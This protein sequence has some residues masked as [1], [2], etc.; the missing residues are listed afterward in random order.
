MR[1]PIAKNSRQ[2]IFQEVLEQALITELNQMLVKSERFEIV[3]FPEL[4]SYSF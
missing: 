1:Q 2:V 4:W 3:I